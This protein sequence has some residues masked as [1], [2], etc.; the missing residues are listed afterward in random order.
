MPQSVASSRECL[1][2]ARSAAAPLPLALEG[3]YLN[4]AGLFMPGPPVSNDEIDRFIAPLNA[5]SGRIKRRVLRDNGIET[6][7]YAIDE[8]G[9]TRFSA[10]ELA[11]RAVRDCLAGSDVSLEQVTLL[12]TGSSGGDTGMPGFANMVHGE[13]GASPMEVSSHQ[14][15][16][17]AGVQALVHAAQAVALGGIRN[18]VSPD[19][20]DGVS[21]G[22]R[23]GHRRALVA[24]SE[25]PSRLFKRSRFAPLG[26]DTDFDSHFLRWMLS[27]G[28]GACLLED[29]PGRSGV[30]L[31]LDWVHNRSFSG[32]FPVCMQV[33]YADSCEQRYYLDYESLAEAEKAG[34]FVLRQDLRLLPNLFEVGIHE[35]A[36]LVR[37]GAVDP[38]QVDHFLC[39]YSSEKFSGVIERLMRDADIAIPRNRWFS[40]LH[41]RGN[42]GAASIFV[43]LADFLRERQPAPGERVLCFVPE[44]GRFTVS[45]MMF[46]VV[47]GVP[48]TVDVS[49]AVVAPPHDPDAAGTA[50]VAALLRDLA[51]VWHDYRS[52]AW[53]TRLV[54][55]IVDGSFTRED[56]LTWMRCWIPQV[57]E[58]SLWMREAAAHLEPP[59][60]DLR[61][62]IEAHAGDE[63]FDFKILF[64][65]YR[66][67]GGVEESIEDLQRNPGGEALNA[68]M[69]ARAAEVNPVGLLGGIYII[70]GTGQRIIPHLL[71][72]LRAC[73]GLDAPVFRFLHYH[74]ENDMAHLA[75]WLGAVELVLRQ[76]SGAAERIVAAARDTANLYLMQ[77]EQSV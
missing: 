35:Y 17:G 32:D 54:R 20:M 55:R 41:R 22:P 47:A 61:P 19:G 39:H 71:P 46:E 40:N 73:L 3:V 7:H 30:S 58:G 16:C 2:S 25:F 26:Y 8:A 15:V 63:Q 37:Q 70:E 74:G 56:Y 62:L 52:R 75:R 64:T 45:F 60:E 23:S 57:R 72:R 18:G 38:K 65:D 53:R 49:E 48:V 11:A 4:A 6:R 67:A 10:A 69:H 28:A 66:A 34:A 12:C 1:V 27:D 51:S 68:Y 24:A 21:A 43:M 33:G 13:L 31:R 29:R 77:M 50:P 36:D 76:D 9:N 59:F 14:G 42:T 5:K 44:S